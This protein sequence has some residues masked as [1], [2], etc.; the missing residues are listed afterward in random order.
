MPR[1]SQK[2][3]K[4]ALISGYCPQVGLWFPDQDPKHLWGCDY[5]KITRYVTL[6]LCPVL[7]EDCDISLTQTQMIRLSCLLTTQMW[8]CD[9]YFGLAYRCENDFHTLNEPIGEILSLIA[10]FLKKCKIMSLLLLWRSEKISTLTYHVKHS[11][12]TV[13]SQASEHRWDC[14][15]CRHTRQSSGLSFLQRNR[16][17]WGGPK[18]HTWMQS[19]VGIVTIIC[20]H[21]VTV[22][23]VAYFWTQFIAK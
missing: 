23:I 8:D 3:G 10:R 22:G 20:Q 1:G 7:R 19:T 11:H 6:L 12:G 18:S 15:L 9:I 16:G 17:D 21:P 14:I 5:T 2:L 13:S 4:L